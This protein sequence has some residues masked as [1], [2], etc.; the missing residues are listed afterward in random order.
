MAEVNGKRGRPR[1]HRKFD[2][3]YDSC[4][5]EMRR[6]VYCEGIG[7]R[8]GKRG[9]TIWAK[10]QLPHGGTWHG[11]SYRPGHA[12]EIKLGRK[13]SVTW[14]DVINKRCKAPILC[15]TL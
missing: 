8:R 1:K 12:A 13:S 4:P 2:E 15:T 11:R 3:L 6:P 7:V 5:L 14:L 10:V 9:D